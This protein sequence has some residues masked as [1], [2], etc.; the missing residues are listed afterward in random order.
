MLLY[1]SV[2]KPLPGIYFLSTKSTANIFVHPKSPVLRMRLPHIRCFCIQRV[3]E[4]MKPN[5]H[6]LGTKDEPGSFFTKTLEGIQI[7][8]PPPS[9]PPSPKEG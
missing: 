8:Q 5:G 4:Y 7:T 6:T 1:S 9:P 2:E 3:N